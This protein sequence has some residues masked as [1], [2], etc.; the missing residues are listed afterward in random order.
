MNEI[1]KIENLSKSYNGLEVVR[2][3]SFSVQKGNITALIGENGAGKTT[4]FNL[5]NGFE[6]HNHGRIFFEGAE[7]SHLSAIERSKFGIE[8]LF[9]NPRVPKNMDVMNNLMACIHEHPGEKIENYLLKPRLIRYTERKNLEKAKHILQTLNL[10]KYT[11]EKAGSLS[12]G[13]KKLLSLGK[14]LMN[15]ARLIL[16]DEPFSGLNPSMIDT[17]NE[18]IKGLT[19]EGKTFVI[20]EHNVKKIELVSN[21]ILK[22]REGQIIEDRMIN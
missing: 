12:H 10:Q 6:K 4:L 17:I 2:N 5:I 19:K 13:Q 16:L 11:Q 3:V 22:M 8:R 18:I 7:I 15:N 1:L 14:L 20:I 21:H 9:Q